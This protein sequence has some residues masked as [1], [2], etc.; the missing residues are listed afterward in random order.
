ML[1][2]CSWCGILVW[3]VESLEIVILIW[4]TSVIL[5]VQW[6]YKLL[7]YLILDV[8]GWWLKTSRVD[9]VNGG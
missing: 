6:V 4:S 1:R 3:V 5:P 2:I 7:W 8:L 9:W